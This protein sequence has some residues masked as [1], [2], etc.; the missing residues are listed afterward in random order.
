MFHQ[1]AFQEFLKQNGIEHSGSAPF[2]PTSNGQAERAVRVIKNG[3]KKANGGSSLQARLSRV[4]FTYRIRQHA[5]TRRT[6]A[7][8]MFGQMLETCLA[9][10]HRNDSSRV[11]YF[12]FKHKWY[13]DRNSIT[14]II[15]VFDPFCVC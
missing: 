1:C 13:H 3:L 12:K 9:L 10:S 11:T 2:K 14:H 8:M 15:N 7:E 5:T 6:P 4:L